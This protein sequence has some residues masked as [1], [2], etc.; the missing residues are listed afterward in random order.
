MAAT[1]EERD[2]LIREMGENCYDVYCSIPLYWVPFEFM[3]DPGVI[4]EWLTPGV[5]G[6]RDFE[7]VKATR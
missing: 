5:F 1:A 2:D 6:V 3:V 4:S 7:Y